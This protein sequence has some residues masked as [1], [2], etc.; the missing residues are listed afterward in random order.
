LVLQAQDGKLV[1]RSE[2]WNLVFTDFLYDQF[3]QNSLNTSVSLLTLSKDVC[4]RLLDK[5]KG[6]ICPDNFEVRASFSHFT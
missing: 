4:C 6:C 1:T 5:D 3:H 2:R